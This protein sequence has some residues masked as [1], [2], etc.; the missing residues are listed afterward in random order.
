MPT[1]ILM[2]NMGFDTQSARIVEW[3]K[4]PGDSVRR[5]EVIAIIESDK[6]NVELE[7]IAEGTLLEQVAAA[8]TEVQVGAVIARVGVPERKLPPSSSPQAWG[9]DR[10]STAVSPL[11]RRI[12]EANNIDLQA[13]AGSGPG[14]K[15]MRRDLES[16]PT[17][18]EADART[19]NGGR[20]PA[21]TVLAL[22]KVRK[23]AREAGIDLRQVPATGAKGQV[24][25]ADL[26]AF[27]QQSAT[28]AP[29]ERG[30]PIERA[31]A[32]SGATEIQLSRM[33]RTIGERL[34]RSMQDAPH[35]Y[36]SG[37]FD[38]EAALGNLPSGVRINDLLQYL[39][40]QT[41]YAVPALNATFENGHLFQHGAV[42]LAIAVGVPDGLITPTIPDAGRYSLQGLAQESRAL[43]QRARDNRLRPDDL[44]GGTFTISNLGVIKQVDQFTAV[45]NPPQ[46]AILAVGTVKARPVVINGGLHIRNTVHLTLSGDHRVVDGLTLGNFMAVFQE[47]LDRFGA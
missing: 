41:L 16:P 21:S 17:Q 3:L 19:G 30:E 10:G 43:I 15:I 25:P 46:V 40:V 36:V 9:E 45:I 38:L 18:A 32:A 27:M 35:F 47:Q 22:P 28:A 14:G 5:G 26:Q 8:D 37:E 6:A 23:A 42:N 7:S 29:V 39:T 4:H 12:A 24:T 34:S 13:V 2:P 31:V 33:R 20:P 1:D 11:A 44:Q